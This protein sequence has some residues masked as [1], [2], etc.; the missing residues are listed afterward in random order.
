MAKKH[1]H[2]TNEFIDQE[3]GKTILAGTIFETDEDRVERLR[4]ADVIG[5]EATKPEIDAAKKAAEAEPDGG[6]D[7]GNA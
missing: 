7:A 5:R 3:S 1:F 2:I 4:A 6:K